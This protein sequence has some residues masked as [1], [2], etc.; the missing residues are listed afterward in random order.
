MGNKHFKLNENFEIILKVKVTLTGLSDYNVLDED[1][2]SMII[3]EFKEGIG[4][5]LCNNISGKYEAQDN[6]IVGCDYVDYEVKVEDIT[7]KEE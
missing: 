6:V 5:E 1:R 2:Q 4:P 7:L 3:N